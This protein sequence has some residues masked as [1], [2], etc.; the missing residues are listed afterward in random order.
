MSDDY[1]KDRIYKYQ[2]DFCPK[3]LTGTAGLNA[4][5]RWFLSIDQGKYDPVVFLDLRY[6]FD[7]VNR[8]ILLA[9]ESTCFTSNLI[10]REQYTVVGGTKFQLGSISH[11]VP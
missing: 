2:S 3:Y 11:G 1:I 8:E 7:T 10:D 9:I 6:A 5:N 4:S